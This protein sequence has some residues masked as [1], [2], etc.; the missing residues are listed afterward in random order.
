MAANKSPA[1]DL[2]ADCE[3]VVWMLATKPTPL[4]IIKAIGLLCPICSQ[5]MRDFLEIEEKAMS[6][7]ELRRGLASEAGP[8]SATEEQ[9]EGSLLA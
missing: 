8:Q 2:H 1:P 5:K 4:R 7:Q 9:S 6:A 3:N